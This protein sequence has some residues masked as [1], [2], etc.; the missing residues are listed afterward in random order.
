LPDTALFRAFGRLID[1]GGCF[2]DEVQ[3]EFELA[4]LTTE[5]ERTAALHTLRLL[6]YIDVEPGDAPVESPDPLLERLW[7]LGRLSGLHNAN[8]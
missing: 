8:A 3:S 5:Q 1:V 6:R 4:G 7:K 2:L